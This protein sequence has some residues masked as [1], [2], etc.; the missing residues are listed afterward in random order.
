VKPPIGY[1]AAVAVARSELGFEAFQHL[2]CEG[3]AMPVDQVYELFGE[4]GER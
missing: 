4:H 1:E 2:H 3:G